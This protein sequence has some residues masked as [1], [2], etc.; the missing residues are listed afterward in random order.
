VIDARGLD[1]TP[2]TY[3]DVHGM[4]GSIYAETVAALYVPSVSYELAGTSESVEFAE[5][6][7]RVGDKPLVVRALGKNEQG[8]G[9]VV[10]HEDGR[11]IEAMA[12]TTDILISG[13][14]SVL[15]VAD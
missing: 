3:M 15:V 2:S 9:V 8:T 1:I 7:P 14:G 11:I 13:G 5:N 12:A 4:G 10:A 6:D